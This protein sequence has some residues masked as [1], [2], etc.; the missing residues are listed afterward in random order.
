VETSDQRTAERTTLAQSNSPVLDV[1]NLH[2][3]FHTNDGVLHAVNGASYSVEDGETL[4]VVGE[5]GSGK[6]V[7]AQAVI[8][9]LDPS[10]TQVSGEIIY[11]GEDLLALSERQRRRLRGTELALIP[12]DS[13][14]ALDPLVPVGRQIGEMFT[15]HRGASRR[16]ALREAI[17]LMKHVGI[18]SA[19]RRATDLPH[20]FSGGMRQRLVIAMGVALSPDL[21]IADEATSALDVTT[22]LQVTTMLSSLRAELG[23]SLVFITHDLLA[24][25]GFADRVVVMYAGRAVESG[26]VE[27][28]FASPAHPYTEALLLSTPRIDGSTQLRP[29][30]GRPPG[31]KRLAEGCPFAPRCSYRR[32]V[33]SV[34]RPPDID[35]GRGHRSACLFAPNY[36]DDIEAKR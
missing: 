5:S 11:R 23:M 17:T 22:Q 16:V 10:A 32:D 36:R 29:I 9:M 21:L 28:I 20:Q 7:T 34:E 19:E 31:L 33:C 4:A 1:R 26:P 24:I 12:Q 18:P 27:T 15:V 13:M 25:R 35:L 14:A 8:G 6:S 30:A 3:E 2:V